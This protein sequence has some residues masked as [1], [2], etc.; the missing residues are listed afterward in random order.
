[1]DKSEYFFIKMGIYGIIIG[2]VLMIVG[3][4]IQ[5]TTP[6]IFFK[7]LFVGFI[8]LIV[9]LLFGIFIGELKNP[10]KFLPVLKI[11]LF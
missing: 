10:L 1:M 6:P 9:L 11:L 2:V 8:C 4:L 5:K 7:V 3:Y